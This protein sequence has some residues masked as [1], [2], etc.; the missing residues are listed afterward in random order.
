M[1]SFRH[2][3]DATLR[4]G[5]LLLACPS[6]GL[7]GY[8]SFHCSTPSGL[9]LVLQMVSGG[10]TELQACNRS[11]FPGVVVALRLHIMPN[12]PQGDCGVGHWTQAGQPAQVS[13]GEVGPSM[14]LSAPSLA[15]VICP[16]MKAPH[17]LAIPQKRS[18][19][20]QPRWGTLLWLAA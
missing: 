6:K 8:A 10:Q 14:L 15:L 4:P 17:G 1:P 19:Q 20:K 12:G 7:S 11:A 9:F 18:S 5:H 16:C 3:D 13:Q 2:G